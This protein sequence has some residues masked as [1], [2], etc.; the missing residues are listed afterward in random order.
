MLDDLKY[1]A[2]HDHSDALGAVLRQ[3]QQL[4]SSFDVSFQLSEQVRSIVIAGVGG[5]AWAG[6]LAV[7]WPGVRVPC[8]VVRDYKLPRYVGSQTLVIVPSFSGNT[9]ESMAC[10]EQ[11]LAKKTQIVVVSSGGELERRARERGVGYVRLPNDVEGRYGGWCTYRA[12]IDVVA[13]VDCAIE[14]VNELA[15]VA[16]FLR[17]HAAQFTADVPTVKN[18]AKQLAE[19]LMGR[20]PVI[21]SGTVLE[22]AAHKWKIDINENAKN[23]AFYG[24]L[25]EFTHNELVGWTSHPAEKPFVPVQLRSSFDHDR[26]ALRFD[27]S[28][29]LLSGRMPHAAEIRVEGATILEQLFWAI[30]LGDAASVY[31]AILNGVDPTKLDVAARLKSELTAME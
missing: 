28:N 30:M 13:A 6:E 16:D 5:S 31:L 11:A 14:D 10:F 17:P 26:I 27:L 12:I 2:Q 9:E 29:K 18:K 15:S 8:E 7:T 24:V 1:I 21:Y 20:T 25:P 3:P 4:E 19:E 22:A 23:V